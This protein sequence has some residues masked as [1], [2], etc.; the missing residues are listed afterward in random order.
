M[1]VVSNSSPLIGL[2]AINRLNLLYDL[3][4]T[5]HIPDAVHQEVV[6]H[7]AGRP[8]D[9][10]V[11]Q[12]AWIQRHTVDQQTVAQL[13]AATG[14]D[15]GESE[16]IVLGAELHADLLIVDDMQA[17]TYVLARGQP[18]IGTLGILLTA[19]AA[20]LI[21]AVKPAMDDLLTTGYWIS[22]ALSQ[23]ILAAANE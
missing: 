21:P 19:K 17:R 14:L 8:G 6:V 18:I 4:R 12:A 23:R 11:A 15:Q 1:I 9:A 7:G 22:P 13:I 16:A 2:A 5:V 3:Y 20:Q 10:A